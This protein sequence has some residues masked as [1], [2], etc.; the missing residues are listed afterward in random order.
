V[1]ILQAV[2][3]LTATLS[4]VVCA[5]TTPPPTPP[6]SQSSG[7]NLHLADRI[8]PQSRLSGLEGGVWKFQAD[9]KSKSQ[10]LGSQTIVRWGSWRG[11]VDRSAVWL[12]DGSW[13]VGEIGW[14]ERGKLTLQN[15]WLEVPSIP[16]QRLRGVILT[17]TASLQEWTELQQAIQSVTG[18]DDVVWLSDRGRLTG[19]VDW[20]SLENSTQLRIKSAGQE[21]TVP[22][23]EVIAIASSPA[24]FSSTPTASLQ[25][26]LNEGSLLNVTEITSSEDNVEIA[27]A[28][29]FKVQS[30]GSQTEFITAVNHLSYP[31]IANVQQLDQMKPASYRHVADNKL[32][33][34]LGVGRGVYG[35]LLRIGQRGNAGIVVHGLALHSRAQVAYLWDKSPGKFLAEVMLAPSAGPTGNALCQ[36]LVAR[37]GNLQTATEF[38]V[39]SNSNP[40]Q[41]STSHLVDVDITDAQLVVLVVEKADHGQLG[42]H[43]QWLDARFFRQNR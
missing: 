12:S 31:Q 14:S 11:I 17:P 28:S 10:E 32:E 37:G 27:L 9:P 20:T 3:A 13:L 25:I 43:V 6:T 18:E 7:L 16:L 1:L 15:R 33:F 23:E 5:Q 38:R 39:S 4:S 2:L 19:V 29:D 24:L 21:V 42:D 41:Q 30:L 40:K 26:G 22:I 35:E 8:V 36:V 34:N